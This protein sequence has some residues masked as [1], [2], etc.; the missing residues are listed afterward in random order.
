MIVETRPEITSFIN[1]WVGKPKQQVVEELASYSLET[2]RI[3]DPYCFTADDDG[4]LFHPQAKAKVKNFILRDS[5]VGELEGRA[6]DAISRWF[7]QEDCGAIVWVSPPYPGIYPTSKVIVSEIERESSG[8]RLHNRAILLDFDADRCLKFARDLAAFS[9]NHPLFQSLDQV[10][11]TPLALNTQGRSWIYILEELIDDPILWKGLREGKDKEAK[12]EALIQARIVHQS[13]FRDTP[14]LSDGQRMML[15]MLGG[16]P[17]SCPVLFKKT[18]FR[19]LGENST[20]LGTSTSLESSGDYHFGSCVICKKGN[21]WVGGCDICT[22][23]E[24]NMI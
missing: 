6:F 22:S 10:R 9:K 24:E 4:D 8:K 18:A 7:R 19:L 16:R 23:C 3:P 15:E 14:G 5:F 17:G 2:K 12:E 11:A 20:I 1:N 21:V 13:L